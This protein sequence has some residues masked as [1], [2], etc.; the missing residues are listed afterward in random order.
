MLSCQHAIGKRLMTILRD[1]RKL[2]ANR[3]VITLLLGKNVLY[4]CCLLAMFNVELV[5]CVALGTMSFVT[6]VMLIF[7]LKWVRVCYVCIKRFTRGK[8]MVPNIRSRTY[9]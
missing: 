4:V 9:L 5:T 6:D 7:V 8:S 2:I 3:S 1:T